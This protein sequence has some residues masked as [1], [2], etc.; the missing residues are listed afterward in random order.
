MVQ[1]GDERSHRH[2]ALW[3]L[4]VYS[5]SVTVFRGESRERVGEKKMELKHL[6]H[7]APGRAD[8]TTYILCILLVHDVQ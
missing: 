7:T 2:T 1:R 6:S 3:L 4:F 5:V 8:G